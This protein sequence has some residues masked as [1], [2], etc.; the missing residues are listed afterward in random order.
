MLGNRPALPLEP[1]RGTNKKRSEFLWQIDGAETIQITNCIM[2]CV[3]SLIEESFDLHFSPPH[4]SYQC[5][6]TLRHRS[7]FPDF[8]EYLETHARQC[9]GGPGQAMSICAAA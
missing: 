5:N 4:A 7:D 1:L 8:P 2:L 6:S 3:I 9:A